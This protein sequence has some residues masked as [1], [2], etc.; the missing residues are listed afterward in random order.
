MDT[1]PRNPWRE[2]NVRKIREARQ[3]LQNARRRPPDVAPETLQSLV[4]ALYEA[5]IGFAVDPEPETDE[6]DAE[7][8]A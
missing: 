6:T 2:R 8:D 5:S 7:A 3:I 1:E 4:L